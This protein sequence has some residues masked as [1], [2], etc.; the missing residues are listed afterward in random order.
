MCNHISG[1]VAFN[2]DLLILDPSLAVMYL[3]IR[4]IYEGMEYMIF[5][6]QQQHSNLKTGMWNGIASEMEM[7]WKGHCTQ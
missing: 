4:W 7:E 1:Y 2:T 5:Y 3:G 6:I